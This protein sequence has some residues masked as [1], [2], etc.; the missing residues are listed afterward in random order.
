[1]RMSGLSARAAVAMPAISPPPPIATHQRVEVRLRGQHL[2]AD[3]ALAGDDRRVVERVHHR[4]AALGAPARARAARVVEG[5]AFEHDLGAEAA[6]ALDLHRRREARHHDRGRDAEPLRRGR[7]RPARG[8]RPTPRS[9]RARVRRRDSCGSLLSAPRSL[10]EAVNCRFSNFRYTSP[11]VMCD[12]VR[13]PRHGV[14]STCPA[15]RACAARMSAAVTLM[16]A[17]MPSSHPAP[18]CRS[19]AVGAALQRVAPGLRAI[20]RGPLLR[21]RPR[22]PHRPGIAAAAGTPRGSRRP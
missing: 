4:Q 10:N 20:T 22:P 9:R 3:R 15:R 6:R 14:S 17:A 13:E 18:R 21:L 1:M 11:P 5:V 2:E 8:C 16:V 12:S 7:R 19:V